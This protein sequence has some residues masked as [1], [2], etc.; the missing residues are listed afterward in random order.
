MGLR[1]DQIAQAKAMKTP[2]GQR[3]FTDEQIDA[4]IKKLDLQQTFSRSVLDPNQPEPPSQIMRSMAQGLT[5][6]SADE[7]EAYLRTL[8]GGDR[9]AALRDI[10]MN[11]KNYQAASPIAS[12]VAEGVG[13]LPY[14]MLGAPAAATKLAPAMAKV[15]GVGT[16]MGAASGAGRA[17]GD[18]YERGMGAI[19]GGVTGGVGSGATFGGFKLLGTIA[20]PMLDFARRKIGD[21]GAKIV[22]TEIQRIA[23]ATGRSPDEIV[24]RVA[25]GE[26]LSENAALLNIVRGY[27]S[28]GGDAA[29][30]IREALSTRPGQLRQAA[31]TQLQTDLTKGLPLTVQSPVGPTKP[32]VDPNILRGFKASEAERTAALNAMYDS[33]Y[34]KG[35]VVTEGML[36]SF[37]ES[38]KRSPS[39]AGEIN[40]LH[41]AKTGEKPFFTIGEKGEISF[42]RAPTLQDMELA[43]RGI[44]NDINQ[45]WKS[46]NGDVAKELKPFELTLRGEINKSSTAIANTRQ[47]AATNKVTSESFDA[48]KKAFGKSPDQI[49]IDFEDIVAKGPDA[50]SAFR[51]GVMDQIRYKFK[52]VGDRTSFLGK[53]ADPEL[54]EGAILRIIYPQDK[55]EGILKLASTAAQSQKASSYVLGGSATAATM[56]A[57]KQ[58]GVNISSQEIASTLGGDLFTGMR[59]LGKYVSAK[60]PNLTPEQKQQVAKILVSEDPKI[61][62]NALR[63]ESGLA[64]L[65]QKIQSL[66]SRLTRTTPGLFS[67]TATPSLMSLIGNQ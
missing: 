64:M 40:K 46:G 26:I 22:E 17:E 36:S 63:D 30:T 14:A 38:L 18:L 48:G 45:M 59:V 50:V 20:D 56:A 28:G 1:E 67:S 58:E 7:I 5:F 60:A 44:Q 34:A 10:R 35:G 9:E 19:T 42:V 49:S 31:T 55:V 3:M 61:V 15:V 11:L 41:L 24:Q 57:A 32:A 25:N 8:S 2:D 37:R 66:S 65:Q 29:E 16:A 12:T 52:N 62:M 21:R 54:K 6:N 27:V 39:A 33:A 51:A 53:I 13:S 47:T 43:R 23:D 4:H